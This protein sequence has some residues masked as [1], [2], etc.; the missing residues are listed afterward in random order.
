MQAYINTEMKNIVTTQGLRDVAKHTGLNNR[1]RLLELRRV[2]AEAFKD[3]NRDTS[4][5]EEWCREHLPA[6]V[7]SDWDT[8]AFRVSKKL[9]DLWE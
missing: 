6:R 3:G 4:P 1:A 8:I 7:A 2:I 5:V 9:L